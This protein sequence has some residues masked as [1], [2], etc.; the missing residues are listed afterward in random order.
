MRV[1][2]LVKEDKGSWSHFIDYHTALRKSGIDSRVL[3]LQGENES[4][5]ITEFKLTHN[6]FE[7]KLFFELKKFSELLGLSHF[8]DLASVKLMKALKKMEFDILHIYSARSFP[9]YMTFPLLTKIKPTI[10]TVT[11]MWSFTGH[12][13]Y[14]YDCNRWK[15]GCGECPHLNIPPPVKRDATRLEWKLKDWIYSHSNLTVVTPS[16]WLSDQV[17]QSILKRFPVHHI[18]EGIDTEILRP[19]D[20]KR[21][22]LELGIPLDKNVLLFASVNLNNYRKG[23]DLLI[24]SLKH[25]P[26]SV[27]N[28]TLL[29]CMGEGRDELSKAVGMQTVSLGYISD[30]HRRAVCYSAADLL[31][32]P[33]RADVLAIVAL[34][35]VACGTPVVS[36]RV[37]GMPDLV[38][39]GLTGYLADPENVEDFRN[40]IIE[41]I[42]NPSL[43]DRMSQHC[44][45]IVEKNFSMELYSQRFSQ[46]CRSLIN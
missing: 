8:P 24:K 42:E 37:G 6:K 44:R 29:L 35:S 46:L 18:P 2:Y 12:C 14:S 41:L 36:F 1:L 17:R 26:D 22:R 31:L 33:T 19:L 3:S 43:R 27:R 34:E 4:S 20:K 39:P 45:E 38:R 15:T 28:R 11:S 23:G 21:C 30:P 16:K 10:F 9:S 13:H 40:G 25:L 32:L 5:Y 7:R